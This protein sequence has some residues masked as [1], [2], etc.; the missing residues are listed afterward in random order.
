MK[1]TGWVVAVVCGMLLPGLPMAGEPGKPDR[2]DD[3][4][5]TRYWGND[6]LLKFFDLCIGAPG[7]VNLNHYYCIDTDGDGVPDYKDYC[8]KTPAW[9]KVS[10]DGCPADADHDGV[11]DDKDECPGT[12]AGVDVNGSGCPMD[13]DGDGVP[14]YLD[15]C[16]DTPGGVKVDHFGCPVDQDGDGV[17]DYLDDCPH[18]P[19]HVKVDEHGCWALHLVILFEPGLSELKPA[20]YAE[21]DAVAEQMK[22]RPFKLELAGHTDNRMMDAYFTGLDRRRAQ[23]V[24]NYLVYRGVA[25]NMLLVTGYGADKPL[26]DNET[27]GGLAANNRVELR[28]R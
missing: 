24:A 27:P 4:V 14:D 20:Y 23:M 3:H 22:Q 18:S 25:P 10:K 5:W 17:P 28:Q 8:P 16:P 13:L 7:G 2:L 21:L 15:R 6:V 11:T 9:S 26:G 19:I 12:P 1:W